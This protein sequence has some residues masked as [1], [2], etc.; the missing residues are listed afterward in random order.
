[1]SQPSTPGLSTPPP[2]KRPRPTL[3]G[4]MEQSG[5]ENDKYTCVPNGIIVKN[6]QEV[7]PNETMD[8]IVKL[9]KMEDREQNIKSVIG[10]LNGI[11]NLGTLDSL[12]EKYTGITSEE[13]GNTPLV[14]QVTGFGNKRRRSKKG[15][16][17]TR[18]SK[19]KSRRKRRKS[20][21]KVIDTSS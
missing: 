7:I 11:V 6:I 15:K 16:R 20:K 19:R 12:S 1:M 2:A 8:I 13:S 14:K 3:S 17:K 5:K 10:V 21:V 9:L 18:K 4:I